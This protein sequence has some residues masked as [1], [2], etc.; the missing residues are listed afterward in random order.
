MLSPSSAPVHAS[1]KSQSNGSSQPD[2]SNGSSVVPN[3]ND[4]QK[5]RNKRPRYA[6]LSLLRTLLLDIPLALLFCLML[7]VL[8]FRDLHQDYFVPF[9][10]AATRTDD[11]LLNEFTYYDRLCSVDDITTQDLNDLLI[12]PNT[13]TAE[14][15]ETIMVHGGALVPQLL[16]PNTVKQLREYVVG[17]NER[18][19]D[20]QRLPV[21]QSEGG[22]R[23][24]WTIDATEDPILS[25]ALKEIASHPQLQ[26]LMEG[27]LGPDPG[28]AEITAITSFSGAS[29]QAW[30][31]DVKPDGSPLKFAR[32]YAHSYSVFIP[33]Q[34]TTA[35][36]GATKL[37]PG[38]QVC[39]DVGEIYDLCEMYGLQMSESSPEG[40][41]HSGDAAILSQQVWHHGAAHRDAN[42]L[43]RILFIVSFLPRPDLKNHRR[44][45]SRGTFFHMR[46]NMWGH[47][48]KDLYNVEKF[49]AKPFSILRSM[50]LWKPSNRNYGF[51]FMTSTALRMANDQQG[52]DVDDLARFVSEDVAKLGIPKD[53]QGPVSRREGAWTVYLRETFNKCFVYLSKLN[54][55]ALGAYVALSLVLALALRDWRLLARTVA[56]LLVLYGILYLLYNRTLRAIRTTEFARDI[57]GGRILPR[58][59]DCDDLADDPSVSNGPTTVPDRMDV[60]VGTRYDARFLGAFDRWLDYHPGNVAFRSNVASLAS[61]YQSYESLPNIFSEYVLDSASSFVTK[62][63]RFLQQDYRSGDWRV[64]SEAEGREHTRQSLL[65]EA[66]PALG[67]LQR[68]IAYLLADHRFG[69]RRDTRLAKELQRYLLRLREEDLFPQKI[70]RKGIAPPPVP[71][72]GL[73]EV[74]G[75]AAVPVGSTRSYS[76]M[77]PRSPGHP[78]W[79]H[80][81]KTTALFD[82]GDHVLTNIHNS[83]N[84]VPSTIV[85]VRGNGMFQV[86]HRNGKPLERNVPA[87]RIR[88]ET[89]V[90]EGSRVSANFREEGEWFLGTVVRVRPSLDADILYDDGDFEEYVPYWCYEKTIE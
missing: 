59:P 31:A 64:M 53:L 9:L 16:S 29:D 1:F 56:R 15:V 90:E 14:A 44:Q 7:A 78:R 42:S 85:N 75:I 20:Q 66:T 36:M 87:S 70:G 28:L 5:K 18:V 51:D 11:D 17:R 30:H 22:T 57:E 10:E 46:W 50:A 38:S 79:K 84:W 8:A 2:P 62:K 40:I 4:K 77:T 47:T 33:L 48:W 86:G 32:T 49:M 37:L 68:E 81:P 24:S 80:G 73:I 60:L 35:S 43:D 25:V 63:G 71:P 52:A 82:V 34:D 58:F 21:S 55:Y 6:F 41:W 72:R 3:R 19:T 12:Q 74:Q 88:R 26:P 27:L 83:G 45:L 69:I 39:G 13:S 54:K 61:Y 89:P 65:A 76:R 23:L 67:L